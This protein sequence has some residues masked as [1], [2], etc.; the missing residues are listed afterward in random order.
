M[1]QQRNFN[2]VK[3]QLY[4][5]VWRLIILALVPHSNPKANYPF[6]KSWPMKRILYH[7]PIQRIRFKRKIAFVNIM[8]LLR[9]VWIITCHFRHKNLNQNRSSVATWL[10]YS[11]LLKTFEVKKPKHSHWVSISSSKMK[12]Q[13]LWS[14][15]YLDNDFSLI[16]KS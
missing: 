14:R 10:S 11:R 4:R 13:W 1:Q 9:L 3:K 16:S 2:E 5:Q 12:N 6:K 15:E 7:T 8:T